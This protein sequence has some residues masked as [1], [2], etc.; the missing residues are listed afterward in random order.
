MTTA[1]KPLPTHIEAVCND[2]EAMGWDVDRS[3]NSV[4]ITPPKGAKV[5]PFSLPLG[6]P[7][8]LPQLKTQLEKNGFNAA[9][10]AWKR[11]QEDTPP[12]QTAEMP[13]LD[14]SGRPLKGADGLYLCPECVKSKAKTPFTSQHPQGM[15]AHRSSTH[16]VMG[17]DRHSSAARKAK[18]AKKTAPAKKA[19][20]AKTVPAP[21]VPAP[22]AEATPSAPLQ[23]NTDL[24]PNPVADAVG[25]LLTVLKETSG[26]TEALRKENE[27]LRD[28]RDQVAELAHDANR[29][30]VKVVAALL[31]LVEDTKQQ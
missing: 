6:K 3:P 12:Q 28:F 17:S 20:P 14:T 18:A 13:E 27:K 16:N 15:G 29:P 19:T 1:L 5:K 9:L 24:L 30:P 23:I 22:R 2:A 8:V 21:A 10:Q 31:D 11:S 4:R 26:D 7:P 25:T